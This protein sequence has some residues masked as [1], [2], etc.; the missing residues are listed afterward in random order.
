MII[1]L[2][3]HGDAL[4]HDKVVRSRHD[5]RLEGHRQLQCSCVANARLDADEDAIVGCA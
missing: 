4:G 5:G 2:A 3:G 1:L